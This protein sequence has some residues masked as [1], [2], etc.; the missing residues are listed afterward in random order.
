MK[1][2]RSQLEALS[3]M[4]LTLI[5]TASFDYNFSWV[6]RDPKPSRQKFDWKRFWERPQMLRF[7]T[8]DPSLPMVIGLIR[9]LAP[10][11]TFA[12][13]PSCCC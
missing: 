13:E 6:P 5:E 8:G 3:L 4:D 7:P 11:E 9:G 2:G 10:E 1:L 12:C